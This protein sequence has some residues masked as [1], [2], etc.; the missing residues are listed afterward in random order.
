MSTISLPTRSYL[1]KMLA[2]VTNLLKWRE[3]AIIRW[4]NIP[5]SL[6]RNSKRLFL[7]SFLH[8]TIYTFSVIQLP[9][10]YLLKKKRYQFRISGNQ[11]FSWNICVYPARKQPF[12]ISCFNLSKKDFNWYYSHI[13]KYKFLHSGTE[14]IFV[15]KFRI[16]KKQSV[17]TPLSTPSQSGWTGV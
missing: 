16:I 12:R 4:S 8:K 11:H 14:S 10:L 17:N 1:N 7:Q 5:M 2:R 15:S 13:K 3:P 9:I 6:I